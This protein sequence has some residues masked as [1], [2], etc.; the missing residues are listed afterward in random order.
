MVTDSTVC[1]LPLYLA[2]LLLDQLIIGLVLHSGKGRLKPRHF[3]STCLQCQ[4]KTQ[5]AITCSKLTI[6]TLEQRCEICSKLTKKPPK[7]RH[8]RRFG[9]FI[10]NFEHISH[11]CSSV[12]NVNFEQVNAGWEHRMYLISI[13]TNYLA[14]IYLH[15]LFRLGKI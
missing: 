9:S 15:L 12:S 14:G 1:N 11:L 10:V 2:N 8:W 7:R 13:T 3:S 4:K 5:T 6:E